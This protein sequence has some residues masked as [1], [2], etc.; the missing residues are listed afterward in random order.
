MELFAHHTVL[1]SIEMNVQ[2]VIAGAIILLAVAM[3][4]Y[5]GREK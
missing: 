1:H 4:S 5:W 3:V 2:T